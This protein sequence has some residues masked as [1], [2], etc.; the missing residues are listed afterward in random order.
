MAAMY[1]MMTAHSCV[2]E[3]PLCG[4]APLLQAVYTLQY[5]LQQCTFESSDSC[6]ETAKSSTQVVQFVYV[7]IQLVYVFCLAT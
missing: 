1:G 7:C 5:H 2:C 4:F 3:G 6:L